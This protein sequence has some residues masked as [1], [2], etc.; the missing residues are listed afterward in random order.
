MLK[1]GRLWYWR[2][3]AMA[4]GLAGLHAFPARAATSTAEERA[5]AFQEYLPQS[6]HPRFAV[7]SRFISQR[8]ERNESGNR[9]FA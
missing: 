9:R 5:F 7:G 4:I 2:H 8:L 3:V 6:R 1:A